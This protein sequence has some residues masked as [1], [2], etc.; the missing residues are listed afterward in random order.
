MELRA[1]DMQAAIA[2][3]GLLNRARWV[4][5]AALLLAA[6]QANAFNDNW[7][8]PTPT[9]NQTYALNS[10]FDFNTISFTLPTVS[11]ISFSGFTSGSIFSGALGALESGST[12]LT[13][14]LFSPTSGATTFTDNNLAAGSYT[15]FILT[16]ALGTGRSLTLDAVI[17]AVPEP[18]TA[19]LMLAGLALIGLTFRRARA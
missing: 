8:I 11:D 1:D 17:T 16:E 18:Q 15:F 14:F 6:S 4:G 5:L 3:K 2:G 19:V 10:G 13:P 7:G 12:I 9:E